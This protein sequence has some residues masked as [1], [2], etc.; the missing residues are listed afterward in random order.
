MRKTNL[1]KII[2][3]VS[4]VLV[5]VFIVAKTSYSLLSNSAIDSFKIDKKTSNYLSFNY[6]ERDSNLFKVDSPKT[7]SDFNGKKQYNTY[8]FSVSIPKKYV[9]HDKVYYDIV[10][11]GLGNKIDE[12][13]L[14]I[15]LT[16]ENDKPLEGYKDNVPV[17]LALPNLVDG[18]LI[19]TGS[20]SKKD[21]VDK[22][23]LR[24]WVDD[25]YKDEIKEGLVYQISIEMK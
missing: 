23:K 7:L 13:Y 24:I 17:Y 2:I 4:F 18:K 16:D 5:L 8:D 14:K 12:K 22:Y 10:I 20:F 21:L 25:N 6:G 1:L 3:S 11:H 19:Y 15:Y 9:S